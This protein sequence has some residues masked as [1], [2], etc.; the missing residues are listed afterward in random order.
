MPG[1]SFHLIRVIREITADAVNLDFLDDISGYQPVSYTHLQL[2]YAPLFAGEKDIFKFLQLLPGVSAGKDGMSG[3]LVR[4]DVYKRQV[5]EK[6]PRNKLLGR[7]AALFVLSVDI[8]FRV[9]RHKA[10]V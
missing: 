4:G 10:L 7:I 1:I 8:T 3:L 6:R 9:H 5:Q 2:K